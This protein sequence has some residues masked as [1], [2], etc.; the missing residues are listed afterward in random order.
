MTLLN[1]IENEHFLDVDDS[2]D[3]CDAVYAFVYENYPLVNAELVH[4]CVFWGAHYIETTPELE[5][6]F[7]NFYP[8]E[9]I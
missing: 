5:A 1:I 3:Y 9:L 2:H 8:E 4:D 6:E 7:A